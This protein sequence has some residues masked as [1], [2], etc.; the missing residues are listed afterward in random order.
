[1]GKLY[2]YDSAYYEWE[3]KIETM[4]VQRYF[5]IFGSLKQKKVVVIGGGT[6]AARR[7]ETLLLFGC[8]ITIISPNVNEIIKEMI[9][10]YPD[11]IW[12]QR[13]YQQGDCAGAFLVV[14]A[15]NCRE[16]NWKVGQECR[17]N[18]IFVSV[19][20]RKEESSFYFPAIAANGAMV[21]GITSSGTDHRQT[22]QA[23]QEIRNCL[24]YMDR[25]E[26]KVEKEAAKCELE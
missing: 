8:E 25:R 17:R 13:M 14:A 5:P 7:V 6:I 26:K 12:E 15:T 16:V 10:K 21:V 20:D 1:M 24:N 22:A 23:A 18:G 2:E 9:L 11:F 4:E 3:R 19:A